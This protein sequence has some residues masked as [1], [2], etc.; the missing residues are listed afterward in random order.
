MPKC[1]TYKGIC[2]NN[3]IRR[4]EGRMT[5]TVRDM[6]SERQKMFVDIGLEVCDPQPTEQ[7]PNHSG[8]YHQDDLLLYWA[9]PNTPGVQTRRINIG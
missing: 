9:L 2:V 6:F 7:T 5:V 1:L 4:K 3:L 8:E